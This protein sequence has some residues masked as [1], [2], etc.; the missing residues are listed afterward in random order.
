MGDYGFVGERIEDVRSR[1]SRAAERSGRDPRTITILGVTKFHPREAVQAAYD[2][3]IR[4]FGENRVQEALDKYPDFLAL[5][6]DAQVHMIGHLQGNKVKKAVELFSCVQSVDSPDLLG[7]LERRAAAGRRMDILLELHTGEE[8]KSGFADRR[9]ALDACDRLTGLGNLRMRGLMTMAPYTDD[10]A[11]V[12]ASFRALRSLFEEIA[13]SRTF[14]DLDTLSMGM[15]ND[16]EIAVEEGATL[17]RL[18]T[19]LFGKR[20]PA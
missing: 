2:A 14:P 7:E 4:V 12:R 15:S 20:D 6:Q 9:S 13:A 17:L 1:I 11:A 18:G 19:V 8:S 10:A 5:R 3:G 16:F